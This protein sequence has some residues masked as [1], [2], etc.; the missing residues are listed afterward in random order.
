MLTLLGMSIF[1]PLS[2]TGAIIPAGTVEFYETGTATPKDVFHDAEGLAPW[3][4]PVTLDGNGRAII[5]LNTD[6]AYDIVLKN[7]DGAE[8][9]TLE[10]VI[11]AAPAV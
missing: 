6:A 8:L 11:A 10:K 9:W 1:Q 7:A 2:D 3:D 4:F 5:F